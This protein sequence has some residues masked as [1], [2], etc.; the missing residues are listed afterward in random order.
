LAIDVLGFSDDE[1]EAVH[2]YI[3]WLFPL[4]TRSA[5]QP[6]SPVLT[7]SEI[8]AIRS[9]VRAVATL[10]VATERM[11]RFYR[12][13]PWWLTSHDH[14]H[15]RI[16]RILHSLRLLVGPNEAKDFYMA[17]LALNE[18]AG[19]PVNTRSLHYWAEASGVDGS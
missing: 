1:L 9:D 10:K 6:H 11:M 2:D 18:D 16:T 14:N 4:P 12:E 17:I 15:L 7:S 8:E 3:Q 19:A 5:A 13:T